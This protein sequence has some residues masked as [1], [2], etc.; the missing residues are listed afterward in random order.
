MQWKPVTAARFWE[1]LE[2]LPPACHLGK[3]FLVGE[4]TRH[5][6]DGYPM[7]RPFL[8]VGDSYYESDEPMTTHAFRALDERAAVAGL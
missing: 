6:S 2:L 4:P 5:D 8:H 1:M 3:G 7:F